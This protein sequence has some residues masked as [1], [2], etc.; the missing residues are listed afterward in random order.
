MATVVLNTVV[1]IVSPVNDGWYYLGDAI[2]ILGL[3]VAAIGM[4]R[5]YNTSTTR[6]LPK[7]FD[8]EE[9]R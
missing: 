9:V 7:L 3:I 6:P 4:I 2:C 5:T 8:R 1:V